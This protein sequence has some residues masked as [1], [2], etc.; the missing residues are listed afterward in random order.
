MVYAFSYTGREFEIEVGLY[1]YY[2]ARWYDNLV[3]EF[4]GEDPVFGSNAYSYAQNNPV[5][6]AQGLDSLAIYSSKGGFD[7]RASRLPL[8]VPVL[9]LFVHP[10]NQRAIKV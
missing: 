9:G 8:D 4:L 5:T 10:K 6:D 3:G 1:Y 7:L 2:R